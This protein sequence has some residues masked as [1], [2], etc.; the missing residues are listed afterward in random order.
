MLGFSNVSVGS[1]ASPLAADVWR[2]EHKRGRKGPVSGS[3]ESRDLAVCHVP[4]ARPLRRDKIVARKILC[5]RNVVSACFPQAVEHT[6][7][8]YN[9]LSVPDREVRVAIIV[10]VNTVLGGSEEARMK[11]R[12][13]RRVVRPHGE[14]SSP[15]SIDCSRHCH[16]CFCDR[17]YNGT[18]EARSVLPG[19]CKTAPAGLDRALID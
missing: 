14:P 10:E 1:V 8:V 7:V 5:L 17:D 11:T 16:A 9:D 13:D 3:I 12:C 6:C 15:L 4:K 18:K 2:R 19:L